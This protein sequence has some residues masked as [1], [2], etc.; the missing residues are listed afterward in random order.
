MTEIIESNTEIEIQSL[1]SLIDIEVFLATPPELMV[2]QD[3]KKHTTLDKWWLYKSPIIDSNC[4]NGS[5]SIMQAI[6]DEING[7][8]TDLDAINAE[9]QLPPPF[10]ETA[11]EQI[12]PSQWSTASIV[13]VVDLISSGYLESEEE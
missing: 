3:V 4:I 9:R 1:S 6:V 11:L 2:L 7:D 5:L 12:D 8:S 13:D 10:G